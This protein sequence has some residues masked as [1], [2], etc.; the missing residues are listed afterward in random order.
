MKI[1]V[2]KIRNMTAEEIQQQINE[3]R[4]ELMKLRFQQATGELSDHTQI[5][6]TRRSIAR[7]TTILNERIRQEMM[8]GEA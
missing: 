3:A 1:K 6:T 7:L 2:S 5:R 4:E 8:E